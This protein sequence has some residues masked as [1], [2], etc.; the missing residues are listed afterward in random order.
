MYQ[1]S[2]EIESLAFNP[3]KLEWVARTGYRALTIKFSLCEPCLFLYTDN[4]TR[5]AEYE[6]ISS[7]FLEQRST[8][9]HEDDSLKLTPSA[10]D[11]H[12]YYNK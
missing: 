1:H 6:F 11:V 7:C 12:N 4:E 5:E 3:S 8:I 9:D 10:R 2:R